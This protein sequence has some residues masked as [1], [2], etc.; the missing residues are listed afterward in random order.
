[1]QIY[2]VE[3][4]KTRLP[5]GKKKGFVAPM[6]RHYTEVVVTLSTCRRACPCRDSLGMRAEADGD[7][8]DTKEPPA[9]FITAKVG[10][11]AG[12]VCVMKTNNPGV[13]PASQQ[14]I[15]LVSW[16]LFSGCSLPVFTLC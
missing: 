9:G 1:M 10:S 12:Y 15:A 5:T 3:D 4:Y 11:T 2:G 8:R 16:D 13:S 14:L 7:V 6:C